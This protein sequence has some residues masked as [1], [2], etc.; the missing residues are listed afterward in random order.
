MIVYITEYDISTAREIIVV[1][2][3]GKIITIKHNVTGYATDV[4]RE[5]SIADIIQV[6]QG[7]DATIY[8]PVAVSVNSDVSYQPYSTKWIVTD[9]TDTEILTS[10]QAVL[11]FWTKLSKHKHFDDYTITAIWTDK[12]GTEFTDTFPSA[13]LIW[14]RLVDTKYATFEGLTDKNQLTDN[15]EKL[16]WAYDQN[17]V[18]TKPRWYLPIDQKFANITSENINFGPIRRTGSGPLWI[19]AYGAWL[20]HGIWIDTELW[21]DY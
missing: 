10:D 6:K 8:E 18:E 9:S 4:F 19:L 1:S 2:K 17:D 12:Y 3:T 16:M 11:K 7:F 21:N 13:V 15:P 20:D 14:R 5:A